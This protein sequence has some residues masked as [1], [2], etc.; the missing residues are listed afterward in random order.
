VRYHAPGGAGMR[1]LDPH[2]ATDEAYGVSLET[3]AA[4]W[5]RGG[6]GG[7]LARRGSL[8]LFADGALTDAGTGRRVLQSVAEAGFGVR[9]EHRLGGTAFQTRWDFPIWISR[10]QLAQDRRPGLR[11]SG[12]RWVFSFSPAF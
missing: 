7:R 3:D 5:R 11:Q 10:P 9:V 1:G 4:L 6:N 8:A 12:W 2:L